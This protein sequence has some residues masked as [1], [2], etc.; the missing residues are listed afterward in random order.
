MSEVTISPTAQ[1]SSHSLSHC[2]SP[3]NQEEKRT[4]VQAFLS[5][6]QTQQGY[7]DAQGLKLSQFKN[8]KAR[9]I[10]EQSDFKA[11]VLPKRHSQSPN[12]L[13]LVIKQGSLCL[14]FEH[15]DS[16]HTAVLLVKGLV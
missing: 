15:I 10:K 5:S 12:P 2:R 9:Y 8:W 13:S 14:Y 3:L 11:V 4:H 7:C 6:G 1:S 16:I